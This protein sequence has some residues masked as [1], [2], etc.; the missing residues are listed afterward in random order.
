MAKECA[1]YQY[2]LMVQDS[3]PVTSTDVGEREDSGREQSL[4]LQET[5]N[6]RIPRPHVVLPSR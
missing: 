3:C 1:T 2:D 5:R 4:L 6:I